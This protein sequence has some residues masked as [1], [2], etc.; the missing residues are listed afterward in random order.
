MFQALGQAAEGQ[1]GLE[2]SRHMAAVDQVLEQRRGLVRVARAAGQ[3][4]ECFAP[5]VG[6]RRQQGGQVATGGIG[7]AAAQG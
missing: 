1:P 3:H 4:R 5:A 2:F 6:R 7:F